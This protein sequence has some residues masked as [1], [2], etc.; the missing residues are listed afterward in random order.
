MCG[1]V[2]TKSAFLLL[3]LEAMTWNSFTYLLT[4]L[5]VRNLKVWSF[6]TNKSLILCFWFCGCHHRQKYF[7]EEPFWTKIS[8]DK[9]LFLLCSPARGSEPYFWIGLV[10]KKGI[11]QFL[12]FFPH[13]LS[14]LEISQQ[15]LGCS[16]TPP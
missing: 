16:G 10:F 7:T 8:G 5:L 15:P 9:L 11:A 13:L 6:L 14:S 2:P 1:T 3:A 4:C 12:F